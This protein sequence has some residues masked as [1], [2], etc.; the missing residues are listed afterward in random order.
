MPRLTENITTVPHFFAGLTTC[1]RFAAAEAV[2]GALDIIA[3]ETPADT[4]YVRRQIL[5]RGIVR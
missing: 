2:L 4:V 3:F 5:V 1:A